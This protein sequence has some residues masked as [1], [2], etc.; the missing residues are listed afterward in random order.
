MTIDINHIEFMMQDTERQL[1]LE[2][3]IS[4]DWHEVNEEKISRIVA[5]LQEE[6]K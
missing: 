2:E 6:D 1:N 5:I 3:V 4:T